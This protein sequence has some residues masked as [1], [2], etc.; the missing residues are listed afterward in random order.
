[1]TRS[2]PTMALYCG[3]GTEMTLP[4]ATS[5]RHSRTS[6]PASSHMKSGMPD[7]VTPARW[8]NS[9]WVNPGSSAVAVTPVPASSVARPSVK[10]VTNDFTAL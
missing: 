6:V 9:V 4:L 7:M 10:T 1:M 3:L 8:W 2:A 5:S